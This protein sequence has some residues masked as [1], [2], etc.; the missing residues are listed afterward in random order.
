MT[1]TRLRHRLLPAI[2]IG[3][4]VVVALVTIIALVKYGG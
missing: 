3:L 1:P 2:G 4:P